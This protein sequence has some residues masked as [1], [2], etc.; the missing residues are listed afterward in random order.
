MKTK[1]NFINSLIAVFVLIANSELIA[2]ELDKKSYSFSTIKLQPKILFEPVLETKNITFTKDTSFSFSEMRQTNY[3][4]NSE[5][6]NDRLFSNFTVVENTYKDYSDFF[7]LCSPLDNGIANNESG[8]D[9]ILSMVLNNFV[10]NAIFNGRGPI[11]RLFNL[12]TE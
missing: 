11:T 10:N 1:L 6:L 2:Q 12:K 8:G 5:A 3:Y 7:R 4:I 9:R